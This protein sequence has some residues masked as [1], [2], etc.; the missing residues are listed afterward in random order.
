MSF[1]LKADLH[2]LHVLPAGQRGVEDEGHLA[3]ER[4]RRG[5]VCQD[6]ATAVNKES[7]RSQSNTSR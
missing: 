1:Y 7:S 2:E 5:A 6:K 3:A 4:R